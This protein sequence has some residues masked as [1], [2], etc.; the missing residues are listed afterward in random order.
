LVPRI[1]QA[2]V[3]EATCQLKFGYCAEAANLLAQA[4]TKN[5]EFDFFGQMRAD[6]L[7]VR[8]DC[9]VRQGDCAEA[10]QDLDEAIRILQPVTIVET[11]AG[12]PDNLARWWRATAR[13]RGRR[14]ECLAAIEAWESAVSISRRI[15]DLPHAV[16]VYTKALLANMLKGHAEALRECNRL[17]DASRADAERNLILETIGLVPWP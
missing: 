16:N 8:A 14:G 17:D 4:L 15:T 5:E 9:A 7:V 2:L 11:A 1:A 12:V 6:I 13:L 3:A 10:E